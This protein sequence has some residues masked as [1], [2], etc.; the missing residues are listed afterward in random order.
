[1]A[2]VFGYQIIYDQLATYGAVYFLGQLPLAFVIELL[3]VMFPHW[4]NPY[5][6]FKTMFGMEDPKSIL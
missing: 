1:M 2:W 4:D 6:S 5:F 3:K